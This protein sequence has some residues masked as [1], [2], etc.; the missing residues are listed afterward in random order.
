MGGGT[1]GNDVIAPSFQR[2]S[3]SAATN[4]DEQMLD[5]RPQTLVCVLGMFE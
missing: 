5:I 2:T 4:P 1:E 3:K